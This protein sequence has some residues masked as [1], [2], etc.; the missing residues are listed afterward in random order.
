MNALSALGKAVIV[1]SMSDTAVHRAELSRVEWVSV[2][3]K[4]LAVQKAMA[5]AVLLLRRLCMKC[6][7]ATTCTSVV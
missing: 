4:A 1:Q 3:T 7:N 6:S 2:G 5:D